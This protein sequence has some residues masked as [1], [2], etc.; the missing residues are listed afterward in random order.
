ML[1]HQIIKRVMKLLTRRGYLIEEQG[2]VYLAETNSSTAMTPL[3]SAACTYHIAFGPRA[4]QKVLSLQSVPGVDAQQ[5]QKRCVSEQGFSLHAEVRC[6][7]NQRN[8]LEQLCRYINRPAIANERLNL[9]STGDVVLRLRKPYQD[10]TTN[11]VAVVPHATVGPLTA[12][13]L[14]SSRSQSRRSPLSL[15]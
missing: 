13:F 1:L 9:N 15:C 4:G 3:Q 6:A 10:G 7:M 12:C 5:A 2:M 11:N 8:K 14:S